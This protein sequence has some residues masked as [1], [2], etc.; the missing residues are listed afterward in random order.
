[1]QDDESAVSHTRLAYLPALDGVRA[2]AVLAVMMFH[3]GY[4]AHGRRLHGS[5]RLLRAVGLPHHV[6]PRRRV[7][8]D[9]DDQARGVLGPPGPPPAARR[10]S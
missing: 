1:M 6:A 3:G 7:A 10:C 8:P 9:A 4:P 2:C 5:R